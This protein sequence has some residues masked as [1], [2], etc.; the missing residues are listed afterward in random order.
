MLRVQQPLFVGGLALAAGGVGVSI[1]LDQFTLGG[2][3]MVFGGWLMLLSVMPNEGRSIIVATFVSA[4]LILIALAFLLVDHT[5]C[6]IAHPACALYAVADMYSAVLLSGTLVYAL[7]L[8]L[9][10]LGGKLGGK[11]GSNRLAV[12]A[13][14]STHDREGGAAGAAPAAAAASAS[15]AP[16]GAPLR[17]LPKRS[18]RAVL[19]SLWRCVGL[20]CVC[21]SPVWLLFAAA[22][23]KYPTGANGLRSAIVSISLCVELG[24]LGALALR[25]SLRASVQAWLASLGEGIATAAGIAAL[26]GAEQP[27]TLLARSQGGRYAPCASTGSKSETSRVIRWPKTRT[28]SRRARCSAASTRSSATRGATTSTRSGGCCRRG[29]RTL[30]TCMAASPQCARE[31]ARA[32]AGALQDVCVMNAAR[33]AA[34]ADTLARCLANIAG[35]C[36]IL[37]G[38]RPS[39]S[40]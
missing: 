3:G 38:S 30:C 5:T 4:L 2:L 9:A 35:R 40:K 27:A 1:G 15:A 8:N 34:R 28:R 25:P 10:L 17:W 7:F 31:L 39:F 37:P 18:P 19:A 11:P 32:L 6:R 16:A 14:A 23:L 29:A 36:C 12:A 13:G 20:L 33:C 26:I 24:V 22:D 21:W